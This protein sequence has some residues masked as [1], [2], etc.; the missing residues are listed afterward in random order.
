MFE[1]TVGEW[2][3]M[4]HHAPELS[5]LKSVRSRVRTEHQNSSFAGFINREVQLFLVLV[6]WLLVACSRTARDRYSAAIAPL[7]WGVARPRQP[8][9]ADGAA[10]PVSD[11]VLATPQVDLIMFAVVGK[12]F[13]SPEPDHDVQSLIDQLGPCA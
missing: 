12:G 2:G 1:W 6:R 5:G 3:D 7:T 8:K 11:P 13:L 9:Q 4:G 10:A